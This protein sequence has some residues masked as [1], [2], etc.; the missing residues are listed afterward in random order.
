MDDLDLKG[1]SGRARLFPLP[2]VVLFPRAVAPLHV[3]EPRYRRMTADALAGDRLIAMVRLLDDGSAR[4]PVETVGC[5]GRVI[6]HERLDDGRFNLLLLGLARIRLVREVPDFDLPYRIAE[7][8][9][10]D[11]AVPVGV[12][13]PAARAS[14]IERFRRAV[15]A[16]VDLDDEF[17]RLLEGAESLGALADVLAHALPLDAE[18]KQRLLAEPDVLARVRRLDGWLAEATPAPPS[19]RGFPPPFSLN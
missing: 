7:A 11:E 3:F 9:V 18:S 17:F 19:G 12:D 8:V 4:P 1:F 15:G 6:R 13:E 16:K 5:L 14:L 2:G 10:I